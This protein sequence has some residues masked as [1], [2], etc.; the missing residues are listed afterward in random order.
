MSFFW[1][2][3]LSAFRILRRNPLRTGLTMLGII[4][5]IGAVVAMVSLGQGATASVQAE[6][7]SLGTNVLI[8]VPGATTV[9]G[10]RGGLGSVS[11]LTVED[12]EDIEKKI[13]GVTTAMYGTRSVLQIIREN[14][15]WSTVVFGTTPDFPDIRNWPIAQGNF[16]TQSD[17]NSAANV[18]VLGKTAVQNLFE[19]GEEVVES[20]IRIRNVPLR[21]IG[22]L[23]PKGQSITGQDQDDLVVLPFSTAERKV[24]GTQFLGTVGI[25]LAAT[26]SQN[27]IAAVVDDVKELLRTRHRLHQ[28]EEDD[29]TIRTMEDIAK[30]IAG[31]SRTMMLMLMGIASI[32]LIVGGIGIMNILLVSVTE[33][34][35]EIGLRMAVGAKR[36]HILLQFLIEAV[37]MTAV[38]GALGVGVGIGVARL[39]TNMMG[40]PTIINTE[41]IV[42]SFFFSLI[43]GLFFGL[44]PANKASKLNPIEALHYE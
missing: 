22:V 40:W 18:A 5:G 19:P 17:M 3:F 27:E 24:L 35:R 32:S 38:G 10:V 12:A 2:T 39:M 25:I 43:V 6:I 44:Y 34:T 30:A 4:I 29:F 11:T 15:N 33:R 1:L 28:S 36:A 7:T 37:I 8:I 13:D 31:T 20:Q 42:A 9:G 21:V 41:A 26:R 16:F 23:A 14:K